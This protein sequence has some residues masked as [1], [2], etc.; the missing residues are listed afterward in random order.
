VFPSLIG[1]INKQ[2]VWQVHQQRVLIPEFNKINVIKKL[3]HVKYNF[4]AVPVLDLANIVFTI[5]ALCVEQSFLFF[6]N[7]I[8]YLFFI[9]L[10][11]I[12]YIFDVLVY[13]FP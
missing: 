4:T 3:L 12:F 13:E 6:L 2:F 9:Y 8:V 10:C 1:K 11:I 5:A 7:F